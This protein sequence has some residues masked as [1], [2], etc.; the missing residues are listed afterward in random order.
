MLN[1]DVDGRAFAEPGEDI[2]A[3]VTAGVTYMEQVMPRFVDDLQALCLLESPSDSPIGL[4]ALADQLHLLLE[5]LE[6]GGRLIEHP[7]GNAFVATWEG[8][9]PAAPVC[10]LLGHHDTVHPLGVAE[11]RMHRDGDRFYAPGTVDMK[12]GLLQGIYALEVLKQAQFQDFHKIIFLSVSDEEIS[13]RYHV[14]LIKQIAREHP[15]VLG[16]EGAGALGNVVTRRK[17]CSHYRLIARGKAAHAGS[18]PE[19]GRNAVLEL[20]HQ[21][22]QAQSLAN[23]RSGVTIN[24]G[25]L[26]GGSWANVVSDFAE[27]LFDVRFLHPEDRLAVEARWQT[28]LQQQLVPG[29]KLDLQPEPDVML[30][31]VAT[32]QSLAV[33][34][35]VR[36]I[37]ENIFKTSYHPEMRGGASDC[38]TTAAEGCPS[39]DGLGAIG[40][41]AHTADEYMLLAPVPN[42][43]A[44]LAGLIASIS[45]T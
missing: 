6:I 43:V 13:T 22:V 9:N 19:N 44:L 40:G 30:P 4:N 11:V 12:G 14:E 25:P 35:T 41:G 23:L 32:K 27:I 1:P 42:R 17:G 28:L 37:T 5:R 10:L 21:I 16:L 15:I 2:F 20:A 29:V 3:L 38:C 36:L 31:M 26:S 45:I 33:A 18:N 24:A 39:I 34:D 8:N 7:R